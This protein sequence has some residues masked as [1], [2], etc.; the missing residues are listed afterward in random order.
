MASVDTKSPAK[1]GLIGRIQ[2]WYREV[3]AE[4]KRVVKP[5]PDETNQMTLVVIGFV[6][7]AGL[8]FA[9]WDFV[10]TRLDQWLRAITQ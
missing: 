5:T 4:L 7:V 3:T 6:I 9:F 2:T 1:T 8:W 10:L